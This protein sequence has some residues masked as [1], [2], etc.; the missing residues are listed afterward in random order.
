MPRTIRC[1]E[2][3]LLC[4]SVKRLTTCCVY[5]QAKGLYSTYYVSERGLMVFDQ[6]PWFS[7]VDRLEHEKEVFMTE[8][9]NF[10]AM[11]IEQQVC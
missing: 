4:M 2:S 8:R 6:L 9:E 11:L 5:S 3:Y 7:V 1:D 10:K